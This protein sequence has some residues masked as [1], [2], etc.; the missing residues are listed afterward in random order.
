MRRTWAEDVRRVLDAM[1]VD[2]ARALRLLY[3]EHVG[4]REAATHMKLSLAHLRLAAAKGLQQLGETMLV[5]P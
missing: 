3:F 4:E 2:Q 5:L 1:P